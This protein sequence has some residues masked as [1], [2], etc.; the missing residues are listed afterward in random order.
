MKGS[1]D[2]FICNTLFFSEDDTAIYIT[3][4]GEEETAANSRPAHHCAHLAMRILPASGL[5]SSPA[6][7][8][9]R[10]ACYLIS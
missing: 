6:F 4:D 7:S 1:L 3:G 9:T 10:P 5:H 2:S 8:G